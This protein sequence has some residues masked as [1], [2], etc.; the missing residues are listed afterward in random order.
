MEERILNIWFEGDSIGVET[1]EGR[2]LRR[3][4]EIYPA[5]LVA[6]EEER[7]DF[8]LYDGNR[9]IRWNRIDEDIC[10]EDLLEE[11]IVNYDN[12]VNDLL[13]DYSY[14]DL[15]AIADHLNMHWTKL[16]RY[17]AG[18]W[19]PSADEMLQIEEGVLDLSNK[20]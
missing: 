18:I 15:K 8:Y 10:L 1:S 4:L 12:A 7:R 16:A 6:T 13:K 14:L 9:S 17:R 11:D 2:I 3:S 19:T 20:G 5:L